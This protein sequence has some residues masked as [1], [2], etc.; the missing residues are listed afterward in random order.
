VDRPHR[1]I[2]LVWR[3]PHPH[4][5]EENMTKRNEGQ[6]PQQ[7]EQQ[8][9]DEPQQDELERQRLANLKASGQLQEG[10]EAPQGDDGQ[11][12]QSE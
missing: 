6:Q 8:G 2:R 11:Q 3:G 9:Q 5:L 1:D 12:G 10:Q 7:A 4:D